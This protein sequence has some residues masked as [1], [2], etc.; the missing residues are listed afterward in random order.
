MSS[1]RSSCSRMALAA[2][3]KSS[4]VRLR[5]AEVWERIALVSGS[6]LRIAPQFGKGFSITGKKPD[7]AQKPLLGVT[8]GEKVERNQPGVAAQTLLS[9]ELVVCRQPAHPV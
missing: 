3:S 5:G 8:V 2:D 1:L 9:P 6:I 7:C 4:K